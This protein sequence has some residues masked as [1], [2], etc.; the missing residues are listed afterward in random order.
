MQTFARKF[1]RTALR[2]WIGIASFFLLSKLL[3][4]IMPPLPAQIVAWVV[5]LAAYLTYS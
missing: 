2:T 5:V 4:K 3:G 1:L